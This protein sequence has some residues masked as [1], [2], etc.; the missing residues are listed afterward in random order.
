MSYNKKV[1]LLILDG[2]GVAPKSQGNAVTLARPKNL[3]K[4]WETYPSTYLEASEEAVGLIKNTNGNSEV[5]HLTIG[6][7]KIHYQ[8]LLKINKSIKKGS[9]FSSE[10]LEKLVKHS[11]D[12]NSDIHLMGCL[13]DGSVHSHIDHFFSVLEYIN[14]KDFTNNVFIHTFTD[15]RDTPQKNAKK[16]LELLEEKT[17]ELGTGE[18]ATICGRAY[19]MDR[20]N[21]LE[22]TQKAFDLLVNQTG[23][24][25]KGWKEAINDAYEKGEIDEYIE[26]ISI[27]PNS[28]IK[29]NDSIL[30]M[31]F[32][33]DR[34]IQLS[35][36]IVNSKLEN[37]FFSGMVEYKS[38]FPK[39]VVAPKEY[40]PLPLGR[41]I[42]EA[43]AKQIKIAESE[44]FPHVTYFFNGGQPVQYNGEE[45]IKIPSPNVAT[46]DL[47]P[48]MSAYNIANSV[49]QILAEKKRNYKLAVVNIANGDMVGHT[50]DLKASIKAVK[51][52]DEVCGKIVSTAKAHGWTIIITSDHGNIERMME[53]KTGLANTE[54]TQ[55]PVPFLIIDEEIRRKNSKQL[56]LGSLS[57]VA[58]TIL[59]LMGLKKAST[60]TGKSL[61]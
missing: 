58:P 33:P 39:N 60:M 48:E 36:K 55:N 7:G 29:N 57:D 32:R 18:I 35:E 31:N 34:A 30:F 2:V 54:H 46:Y 15:G 16:Y 37:I 23:R 42:S 27:L 44:K 3:I 20:N 25:H 38:G 10:T 28:N 8:N 22:R 12:N 43:G 53:P 61:V 13:S 11:L 26:P 40:L 59:K 52:V 50:G 21:N 1:L 51:V 19:A 6:S 4:F 49:K 5:G 14:K 9:F 56:K 47:Q 24:K 17:K 41:I 45:R